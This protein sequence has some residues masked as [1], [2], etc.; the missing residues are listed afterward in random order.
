MDKKIVANTFGS[1]AA[2][3]DKVAFFQQY[4]GH[5]L[6]EPATTTL[7]K[8]TNTEPNTR[9]FI[10]DAGC[11]TGFL[12]RELKK[13]PSAIEIT[14]LDLSDSMLEVAKKADTATHYVKGDIE[15]LPFLDETFHMVVS[16]L[17]LQWCQELPKALDELVRVLK[18]KGSLF[19]T[20]LVKDSLHELKTTWQT[21]DSQPHSL[22]FLSEATLK[23]ILG[24]Y[25]YELTIIPKTFYFESVYQILKHLKETGA[26][27]VPK[28][29][30]GLS[31]K[32]SFQQFIKHYPQED[33]GYPLTY[34]VALGVIHRA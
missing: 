17:A 30:Q 24:A 26:S 31:G 33:R 23:S 32:Q 5:K 14:A 9:R 12:S 10:L 21:I 34:K 20:T 8:F 28:R 27:Y 6:L 16:N 29:K 22:A 3:Y 1:V 4:I 13:D 19:F 7:E 18:H 11:G 15:S 2:H 25:H